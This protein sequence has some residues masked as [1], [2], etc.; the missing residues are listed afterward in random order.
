M[1][2]LHGLCV[3]DRYLYFYFLTLFLIYHY[4]HFL[5]LTLKGHID[6]VV[7]E[8]DLVQPQFQSHHENHVPVYREFIEYNPESQ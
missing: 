6:E 7:Y 3:L 5:Y 1:I 2:F 4:F 8:F